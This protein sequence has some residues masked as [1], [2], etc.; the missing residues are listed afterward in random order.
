MLDTFKFLLLMMG[1][2]GLPLGWLAGI[3]IYKNAVHQI[4]D[5]MSQL[6]ASELQRVGWPQEDDLQNTFMRPLHDRL[7]ASLHHRNHNKSAVLGKV[8]IWGLPDCVGIADQ[9]R[10]AARCYRSIKSTTVLLFF[11]VLPYFFANSFVPSLLI[12]TLV[13]CYPLEKLF[14]WPKPEGD[15]V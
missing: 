6:E 15:A 2:V 10:R 1:I 11:G 14:S 4:F 13:I 8:W 9:T 7:I 12:L 5:G 3:Q